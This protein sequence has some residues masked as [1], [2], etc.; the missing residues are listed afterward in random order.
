M[1]NRVTILTPTHSFKIETSGKF[2]GYVNTVPSAPSTALVTKGI[3]S[4]YK[5]TNLKGCRHIIGID[6]K[7]QQI[8]EVYYNNLKGL[9]DTVDVPTSRYENLE[10][11]KSL[12]EATDP[13][14]T[15][16]KLFLLLRDMVETDYFLMWEHDWE[17]ITEVDMERVIEVMDKYEFIN[18]IR[19]GAGKNEKN[20]LH[21]HLE[22]EERVPEMPLLRSPSWSGNPHMCRTSTWKHWWKRLVYPTPY[23]YVE[24][25]LGENY[26][27]NLKNMGW[28][29]AKKAWGVYLYGKEGE[30]PFV[31]HTDGNSY[32]G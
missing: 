11:I 16:T 31:K 23:C 25:S 12:N 27:Y 21:F 10:V 8:D 22:P 19:F 30:G 4:I 6:H 13:K 14:I 7:G 15:A 28:D 5:Y 29:R 26:E 1:K 9:I 2:S 18:Y 3:D 24:H 20:N 32:I 17:F